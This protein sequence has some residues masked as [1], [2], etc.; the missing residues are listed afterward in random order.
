[1]QRRRI[2]TL[3][4]A[5]QL[6]NN[7]N[8]EHF[9]RLH[10]DHINFSPLNCHTSYFF[11]S[12]FNTIV[13]HMYKYTACSAFSQLHTRETL[14]LFCERTHISMYIFVQHESE[15]SFRNN[16]EEQLHDLCYFLIIIQV[17]LMGNKNK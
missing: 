16:V 15:V 7:A 1:M 6:S 2:V 12:H 13:P 3:Q 14:L 5:V 17:C 9:R 8:N 11:K 10:F 4:S